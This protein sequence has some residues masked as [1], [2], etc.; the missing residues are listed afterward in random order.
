MCSGIIA[1]V[2]DNA[3]GLRF[4][5]D[6]VYKSSADFWNV[7][8]GMSVRASEAMSVPSH[9]GENVF[10]MII[11]IPELAAGAMLSQWITPAPR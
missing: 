10:L 6:T 8:Q 7:T 5:Q 9:S 1:R 4:E 2:F 3:A 11:G